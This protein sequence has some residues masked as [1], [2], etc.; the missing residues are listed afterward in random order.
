M[1]QLTFAELRQLIRSHLLEAT[2][3]YEDV[4][5]SD[6]SSGKYGDKSH[7]SDMEGLVAGMECLRNQQRRG[8]AARSIYAN[9]VR[10][11]KSQIKNIRSKVSPEVEAVDPASIE[12]PGKPRR[13]KPGFDGGIATSPGH[14]R[15]N[16][17]DEGR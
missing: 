11:L 7:V 16:P 2:Q 9:A 6:G 17:G 10:Q 14:G 13:P 5:L 3:Y 8:T 4:T 12:R 1:V 15:Y